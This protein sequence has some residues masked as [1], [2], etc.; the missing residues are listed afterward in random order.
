MF[1]WFHRRAATRA[2]LE[3]DAKALIERFGEQASS[4][5]RFRQHGVPDVVDANRPAGHWEHVKEAIRRMKS[6]R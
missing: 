6:R 3:A 2:I 4:E 5:A 1:A